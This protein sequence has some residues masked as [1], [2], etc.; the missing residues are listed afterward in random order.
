MKESGI[1]EYMHTLLSRD[2]DCGLYMPPDAS[3]QFAVFVV[4]SWA[5]WE[6][7]SSRTIPPNSPT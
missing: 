2:V 1:E 4:V 3:R 6:S 5:I 7:P